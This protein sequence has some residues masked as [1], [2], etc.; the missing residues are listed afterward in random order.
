MEFYQIEGLEELLPGTLGI[1]EP[2]P[3]K[4]GQMQNERKQIMIVPGL[5]FDLIGNR[6]GFG[7]GYYDRYFIEHPNPNLKKVAIAYDFQ[8]E[9]ELPA[10]QF[11]IPMQRI[12]TEKRQ[13]RI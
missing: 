5:A 12:V 10:D 1:L 3:K 6:I 9:E 11:D 7:A 2:E 8:I 4:L 13:I